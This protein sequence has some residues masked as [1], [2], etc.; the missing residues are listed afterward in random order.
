MDSAEFERKRKALDDWKRNALLCFALIWEPENR[1]DATAFVHS[2]RLEIA[3]AFW[4]SE[5]H[6]SLN[7][8]LIAEF[9]ALHPDA[10][11]QDDRAICS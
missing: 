7:Q 4:T 9:S 2:K 10:K 8:R 6:H 1:L 11:R 3:R 5:S